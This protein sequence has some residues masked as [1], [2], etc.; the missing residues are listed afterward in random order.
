MTRAKAVGKRILVCRRVV[1]MFPT[2]FDID[3]AVRWRTRARLTIETTNWILRQLCHERV[4]HSNR[5]FVCFSNDR[6]VFP[7]MS[8]FSLDSIRNTMTKHNLFTLHTIDVEQTELD[9]SIV[10]RHSRSIRRR[11]DRAIQIQLSMIHRR[12]RFPSIDWLTHRVLS[13]SSYLHLCSIIR[14]CLRSTL[15]AHDEEEKGKHRSIRF[16]VDGCLCCYFIYRI[17]WQTMTQSIRAWACLSKAS[18]QQSNM[19]IITIWISTTYEDER[20]NWQTERRR[21]RRRRKNKNTW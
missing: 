6:R 8:N 2:V 19:T 3:L 5:L 7:T 18:K 1:H 16:F 10:L 14:A 12:Q 4:E 9:V 11:T 15:C 20:K 13:M 17:R 21:R